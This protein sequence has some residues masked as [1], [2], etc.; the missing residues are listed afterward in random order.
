MILGEHQNTIW[1]RKPSTVAVSTFFLTGTS[2][3]VSTKSFWAGLMTCMSGVNCKPRRD[4]KIV[5]ASNPYS[6]LRSSLVRS[7]PVNLGLLTSM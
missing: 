7:G 3:F 2:P 6:S 5:E 1:S 4:G